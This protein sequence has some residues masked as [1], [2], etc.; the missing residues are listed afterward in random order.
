MAAFI[1][2]RSIQQVRSHAQKHFIKLVGAS[3]A[4]ASP[5]GERLQPSAAAQARGGSP[6]DQ[7]GR[8]GAFRDHAR[9]QAAGGSSSC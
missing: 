4:A 9:A 3:S 6:G 1:G 5:D 2:T 7:D 8:V